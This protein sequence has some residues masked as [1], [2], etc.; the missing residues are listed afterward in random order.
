[1]IHHKKLQFDF[2]SI[3]IPSRSICFSIRKSIMNMKKKRKELNIKTH[4]QII[5]LS[6]KKYFI[7]IA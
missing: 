2:Q 4:S 1:M 6:K 7:K 3:P 5:T